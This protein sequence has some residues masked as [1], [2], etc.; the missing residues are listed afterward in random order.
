MWR[1]LQ[2]RDGGLAQLTSY[3]AEDNRLR[4]YEARIYSHKR[5]DYMYMWNLKCRRRIRATGLHVAVIVGQGIAI[6]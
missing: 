1:R 6:V 3:F 5:W 4:K 2:G